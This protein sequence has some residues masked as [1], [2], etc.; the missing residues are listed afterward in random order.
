MFVL[1]GL[2]GATTACENRKAEAASAS[3]SATVVAS[4][5]QVLAATD[6]TGNVARIVF[7]GKEHACDCTRKKVE[8]AQAALQKLLGNPAKIPVETLLADT[9]EDKVA[10]YRVMR[11]MLAIPAIY[12]ID[13]KGGLVEMLQGEITLAQVSKVLGAQP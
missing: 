1:L 4:A 12:F 3:A 5:A 10:P 11:P 7:I 8:T 9:Q 13:A 2:F 6:F